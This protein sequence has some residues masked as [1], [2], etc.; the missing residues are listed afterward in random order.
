V[1]NTKR[2]SNLPKGFVDRELNFPP[3]VGRLVAWISTEFFWKAAGNQFSPGNVLTNR[4]EGIKFLK[5][6]VHTHTF[7]KIFL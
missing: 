2:F 3:P 4:K 7:F 1:L 5:R 6:T